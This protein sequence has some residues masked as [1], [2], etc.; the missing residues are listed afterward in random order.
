[1]RA[2]PNA[3]PGARCRAHPVR[4]PRAPPVISRRAARASLRALPRTPT[5]HRPRVPSRPFPFSNQPL[6][7]VLA[8]VPILVIPSEHTQV[9]QPAQPHGE[10]RAVHRRGG[11]GNPRR[12]CC[13][14]Q[15]VGGH[16]AQASPAG[17]RRDA[18]APRHTPYPRLNTLGTDSR[19]PFGPFVAPTLNSSFLVYAP[20]AR[21]TFARFSENPPRGFPKSLAAF[22]SRFFA[23]RVRG[24]ISLAA[25]RSRF[26]FRQSDECLFFATRPRRA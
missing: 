11:Q 19:I 4:S 23:N 17:A 7:F 15:Q 22:R 3:S 12:A 26:F 25:F 21:E 20:G 2:P 13:V 18:R 9:V 5:P 14:R 8:F 24:K 6:A 10:A 16:L 1:M